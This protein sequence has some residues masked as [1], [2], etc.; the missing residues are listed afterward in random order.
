MQSQINKSALKSVE[1]ANQ[2]FK[3]WNSK[4]SGGAAIAVVKNGKIVFSNA[5]GMANLEYGIS[6][7]TNTIF[8]AASLSKQFTTYAILAL[9]KEG[10]ISLDDDV[11]KYIPE[12][13]NFGKKITLRHLA[14]HTSG[15]R[16]QW[17]L[18]YLG[19]WKI[20]DVILNK[21]IIN[22][23]SKQ[24]SLN[25]DPGSKLSYSNT[26]FTLLAEVVARVSGKSFA[27]YTQDVIFKPLGM[28]NSQF[29]D[30]Y[31]KIV[32]N[33]A[34]SYKTKGKITKKS[35]L[36]FATVGATNLFTTVNDLCKWAIYLNNPTYKNK[37]LFVRMN[38]PAKL[39]N[40]EVTEA[41]M[42]QWYGAKYK[43]LEWFDHTGSD[44]SFRAYFSRFPEH[45]S[46]VVILAN[47][48]PI[49]ASGYALATA[50]IFLK[51]YY[52]TE[53][54]PKKTTSKKKKKLDKFI[55]LKKSQLLKYCGKYWEPGEWYNREIKLIN[56]TLV[57][58]R[59]KNSET[60]LAPIGE[61]SFKMLGDTNDVNVIF[62]KNNK[63]EKI[64]RVVINGSKNIPFF[65]YNSFSINKYKGFF[66]SKEV[67]NTIQFY[68]KNNTVFIKLFKK[69]PIQLKLIK[70]DLFTSSN[71]HFKQ[72]E[73]LRDS[74]ERISGLLVSNGGITNLKYD[75][76]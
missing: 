56:D 23:V 75:K 30:D 15:L 54:Q 69:D 37:D 73:I 5:Y 64:M 74:K 43:G 76:I 13:P 32:K 66:F 50:D 28:T 40:G 47:T 41:A 65:K 8:H 24:T 17:R 49:N 19:G 38:T 4:S 33:R 21:D 3:N 53:P 18:L 68:I 51:E 72:I 52:K 57:Y 67:N 7:T 63:N 26:G 25:F 70:K 44:A 60:K 45:N 61:N 62:K 22:L 58:Y 71:R 11:R 10:K 55:K 20:D 59:D 6:N 34:Y 36:S 46:A 27:E 39:N 48:T 16:D 42:G 12:V 35:K 1:K 14:S 29:Y 2:Y 9:E 31:E